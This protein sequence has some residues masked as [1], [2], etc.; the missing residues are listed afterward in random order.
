MIL[1]FLKIEYDRQNI[2]I[3]YYQENMMMIESDNDSDDESD[4]NYEDEKK[5]ISV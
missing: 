1:N 2:L 3:K 5:T 4:D